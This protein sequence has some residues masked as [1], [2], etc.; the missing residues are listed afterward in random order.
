MRKARASHR[1][2]PA[3]ASR[4][5][6]PRQR[7]RVR[8]ASSPCAPFDDLDASRPGKLHL[9]LI[10]SKPLDACGRSPGALL[11]L[12]LV[13][14][15]LVRP[16]LRLRPLQ[17]DEQLPRLVTRGDERQRASHRDCEKDEVELDHYAIDPEVRSAARSRALRARGFVASS[18]SPGLSARPTSFSGGTGSAS[19]AIG[20]RASRASPPKGCEWRRKNSFTC[21]SSSEWKLITTRRPPVDKRGRAPCSANDNSSSS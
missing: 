14:F 7:P 1:I 16:A 12:Q 21:R 3:H 4:E 17:F 8:A 15:D 10:A 13:V 2:Q 11:E 18:A 20:S 9:E 19:V 5:G 6:A